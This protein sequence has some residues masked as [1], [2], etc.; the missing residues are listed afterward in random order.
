MRA[1]Q[2]FVLRMKMTKKTYTIFRFGCDADRE[3]DTKVQV[4]WFVISST[5][6]CCYFVQATRFFLFIFMS[7]YDCW[8]THVCISAGWVKKIIL[9]AFASHG[10]F[11]I[12]ISIYMFRL[13]FQHLVHKSSCF[14][15][16]KHARRL[17]ESQSHHITLHRSQYAWYRIAS[18]FGCIEREPFFFGKLAYASAKQ[19]NN[20]KWRN[21]QR[22]V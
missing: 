13:F 1:K 6:G 16:L 4:Q 11:F 22:L 5:R 18:F 17:Y 3:M 8:F 14:C 2:T 20:K 15:R 10:S 7:M 12:R 19:T 21:N 9:Y